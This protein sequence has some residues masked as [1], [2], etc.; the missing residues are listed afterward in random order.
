MVQP[1]KGYQGECAHAV[2]YCDQQNGEKEREKSWCI[3]QE[4]YTYMGTTH[5]QSLESGIPRRNSKHSK[6]DEDI[7]DNDKQHI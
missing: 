1:H 3:K 6:K 5:T 4:N 7:R 2:V